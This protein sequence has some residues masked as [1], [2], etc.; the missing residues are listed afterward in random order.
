MI[1]FLSD[2]CAPRNAVTVL[3]EVQLPDRRGYLVSLAR[4]VYDTPLLLL[5][6]KDPD[7]DQWPEE[8]SKEVQSVFVYNGVP[9]EKSDALT[10]LD[11]QDKK[12]VPIIDWAIIV[13]SR[14]VDEWSSS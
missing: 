6:P 14:I 4:D 5:V 8:N 1:Y 9:F 13:S 2:N 12:K 11:F 3:K 7:R 10:F